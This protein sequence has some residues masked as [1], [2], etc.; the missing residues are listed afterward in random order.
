MMPLD[1]GIVWQADWTYFKWRL[2][3]EAF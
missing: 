2:F 3:V 1:N